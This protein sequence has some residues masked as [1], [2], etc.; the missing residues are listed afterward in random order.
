MKLFSTAVLAL[1]LTSINPATAMAGVGEDVEPHSATSASTSSAKSVTVTC[2]NG[3]KVVGTGGAV[4]GDRTAI[5]RIKPKADLSG[6]EV[7]ATEFGSGTPL[8]WTVTARANC[9]PGDFSLA[10]KNG[11]QTAEASCPTGTKSLGVGAEIVDAVNGVHLTHLAPQGNLKGATAEAEG[12]AGTWSVTAYAICGKSS[13]A[14]LRS[15]GSSVV[16]GPNGSKSVSCQGDEKV[17]SAGGSVA[18]KAIIGDV[19][20]YE[21]AAWLTGQARDAQT[22]Q[23]R[24]SITP[25]AVCSL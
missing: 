21:S 22:Q 17:I 4:T 12:P 1:S 15:G 3:W 13:G 19:L 6:V 23:I 11:A 20:P 24:W 18:G 9:A 16:I 8:P 2:P 7:H 5:T 14:V 25:Y 10:S